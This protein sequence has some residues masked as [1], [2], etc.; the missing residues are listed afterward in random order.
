MIK[1]KKL[2]MKNFMSTGANIQTVELDN[3]GVTLVMGENL[4]L[5][6]SGS[7]NGVGKCLVPET[8]LDIVINDAG[9]LKT[10]TE[11]MRNRLNS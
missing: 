11:F 10:F 1:F 5:G 2:C 7:K 9:T 3:P 8:V 4:D 6:G